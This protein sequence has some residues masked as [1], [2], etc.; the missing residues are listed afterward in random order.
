MDIANVIIS[1]I[2][3]LVAL[4]SAVVAGV[5]ALRSREAK[6]IAEQKRDEA[7]AAASKVATATGRIADVQEQRQTAEASAQASSIVIVSAPISG[8]GRAGWQVHNGSAQP[9]TQVAVST[10]TGAQIQVYD[11]DLTRF[12]EYIEHTLAGQS[13]SQLSFR[14]TD[15]DGARIDPAEVGRI[16]LRFT[17]THNQRW[18]RIGTAPP[19]RIDK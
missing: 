13:R 8:G 9:V 2:S 15:A 19:V 17:D 1:G 11:N 5:S 7:V 10:A 4:V 18:E 3:A 14:P 12:E 16:V 6:Q